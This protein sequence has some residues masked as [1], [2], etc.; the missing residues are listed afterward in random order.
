MSTVI[1]QLYKQTRTPKRLALQI[2]TTAAIIVLG[3]ACLIGFRIFLQGFGGTLI[4]ALLMFA[5]VYF[6]YK[7][8]LINFNV[9]FEYTY[10]DGELD[11]DKIASQTIRTQIISVNCKNFEQ[12]GVYDDAAKEKLSHRQ[13]DCKI[14]TSSYTKSQQYYAVVKH[15]TKGL[16]LL[17]IEPEE[18]I[19][20]DMKKYLR[21]LQIR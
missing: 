15:P 20:T 4:G 8:I 17:L 19:L 1:E 5:I 16:T 2:L 12:F 13:F 7:K 21:H 10:M 3:A 9:E 14:D 11:I 18:R 6:G